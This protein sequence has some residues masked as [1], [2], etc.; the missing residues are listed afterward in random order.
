MKSGRELGL[1]CVG[2]VFY[3]G[4]KYGGAGQ[5][6]CDTVWRTGVK[7]AAATS[8]ASLSRLATPLYRGVLDK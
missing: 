6:M 1:L 7:S 2:K 5:G 8:L 3:F 4:S